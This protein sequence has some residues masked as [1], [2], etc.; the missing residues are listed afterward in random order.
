ML[1]NGS[2]GSVRIKTSLTSS[3]SNVSVASE[4]TVLVDRVKLVLGENYKSRIIGKYPSQSFG[5]PEGIQVGVSDSR[6]VSK[7]V[8]RKVGKSERKELRAPCLHVSLSRDTCTK[9]AKN[10][11]V[12]PT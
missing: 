5:W 3:V 11:G 2:K 1:T 10:I 8:F 4:G 7:S 6:K 12:L 9:N